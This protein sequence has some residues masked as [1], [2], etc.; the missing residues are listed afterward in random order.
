M[1]ITFDDRSSSGQSTEEERRRIAERQHISEQ[2]VSRHQNA[3]ALFKP[4]IANA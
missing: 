2:I 3:V 1:D 4:R